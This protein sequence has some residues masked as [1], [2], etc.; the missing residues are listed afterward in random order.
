MTITTTEDRAASLA[1]VPRELTDLPQWLVWRL[2][3]RGNGKPTKLPYI[4]SHHTKLASSTEPMTWSY[5]SAAVKAYARFPDLAGVGF[6]F[7]D[8]G[9]LVGVD[10]DDSLDADGQLVPWARDIYD[11]CGLARTYAEV[12]PSGT[13]IKAWAKGELPPDPVTG[14]V[15]TGRARK[16]KDAKGKPLGGGIEMYGAGRYFA[17]TGRRFAGSADAVTEA[18]PAGLSRLFLSL[19]TK[20]EARRFGRSSARPATSPTRSTGAGGSWRSARTRSPARVATTPRSA[21][22]ASASGS[23]FPT[24]RPPRCSAGGTSPSAPASRGPIES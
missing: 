11:R 18:D 24:A 15:S 13:G 1:D 16:R 4:A 6:A 23:T 8:G 21:P 22:R 12:S 9:G 5:F 19:A 14:E 2:K 10:L 20:A 3:A 7:R 17:V